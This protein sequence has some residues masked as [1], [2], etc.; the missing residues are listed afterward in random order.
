MAATFSTSASV[1]FAGGFLTS[2]CRHSIVS[3]TSK[4]DL[5]E[6]LEAIIFNAAWIRSCAF[7][8]VAR[9]RRKS[10]SV[11]IKNVVT[12]CTGNIVLTDVVLE[13]GEAGGI[14]EAVSEGGIVDAVEL[15][16]GDATDGGTTDEND[17][18]GSVAEGW[19]CLVATSKAGAVG[20]KVVVT[21]G[22]ITI[23]TESE[24][25][26]RGFKFNGDV[27]GGGVPF[28]EL[29][30]SIEVTKGEGTDEPSEAG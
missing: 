5:V 19:N 17:D 12:L 10:I 21:A 3:E 11:G 1:A 26:E 25:G 4:S 2:N 27:G 7:A 16:E 30:G 13:A 20:D 29:V 22:G 14:V 8:S 15:E 23:P 6:A 9:N 24:G 18:V 28:S